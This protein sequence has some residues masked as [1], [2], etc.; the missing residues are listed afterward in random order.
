MASTTFPFKINICIDLF[1]VNFKSG[2]SNCFAEIISEPCE[3]SVIEPIVPEPHSIYG[4]PAPPAEVYGP[5]AEV[6]GPP[7]EVYGPPPV[8]Y[9]P[10]PVAPAL[11]DLPPVIK[12]MY[13]IRH[14]LHSSHYNCEIC[15]LIFV[16]VLLQQ[17]SLFQSSK[18]VSD[19]ILN[20]Y[21]AHFVHKKTLINAFKFQSKK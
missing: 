7:A 16:V 15:I 5:P 13:S 21:I 9:I 19:K 18:K 11:L 6:Y 14:M 8:V 2:F 4:L 1:A 17:L 20:Q 12:R 10:P 3:P